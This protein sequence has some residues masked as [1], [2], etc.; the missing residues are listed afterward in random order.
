M[1]F[2]PCH[3]LLDIERD[4]GSKR[5][6]I[7]AAGIRRGEGLGDHPETGPRPDAVFTYEVD[8]ADIAM[9]IT[10][11]FSSSSELRCVHEHSLIR[12]ALERRG[13]R[14]VGRREGKPGRLG[15]PV[16]WRQS[17]W[18]KGEDETLAVDMTRQPFFSSLKLVRSFDPNRPF[19]RVRI[20]LEA[21]FY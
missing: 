17:E 8:D 1:R 21:L 11:S 18:R 5:L 16:P 7:Y 4:F 20:G 15:Q 6:R 19:Q 12:P 3:P 13:Y 2:H 14:C 10:M 9:S